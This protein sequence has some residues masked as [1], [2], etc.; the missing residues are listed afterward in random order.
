MRKVQGS[1]PVRRN[2]LDGRCLRTSSANFCLLSFL[3]HYNDHDQTLLRSQWNLVLLI[4]DIVPSG[5]HF[6]PRKPRNQEPVT[7]PGAYHPTDQSCR[8]RLGF[9][10]LLLFDPLLIYRRSLHQTHQVGKLFRSQLTRL[11]L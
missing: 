4:S 3:L 11:D 9:P 10:E 1:Y 2:L 5:L 8:V 7:V 6:P